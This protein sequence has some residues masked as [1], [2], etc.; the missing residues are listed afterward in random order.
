[1]SSIAAETGGAAT[2]SDARF[3]RDRR[4]GE[5]RGPLLLGLP[6][7]A[8]AGSPMG[9]SRGVGAGM[10]PLRP[11]FQVSVCGTSA[12]PLSISHSLG[13]IVKALGVSREQMIGFEDTF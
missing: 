4:D 12:A 13:R 11:L 6:G 7:T 1:V 3:D 5:V 9:R 10:R 8:P 2:P